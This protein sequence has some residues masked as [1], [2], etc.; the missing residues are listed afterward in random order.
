MATQSE[1][2]LD[3]AVIQRIADKHG[4]TPAQARTHDAHARRTRTTHTHGAHAR[5][6]RTLSTP[7]LVRTSTRDART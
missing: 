7:L 4:K 6:T 2:A 5:R 1:S 3:N